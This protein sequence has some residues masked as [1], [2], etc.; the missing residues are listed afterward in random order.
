VIVRHRAFGD[1]VHGAAKPCGRPRALRR[2]QYA[3]TSLVKQRWEQFR[4][5]RRPNAKFFDGYRLASVHLHP[6]NVV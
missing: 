4:N 5:P 6:E 1:K 3:G 2:R